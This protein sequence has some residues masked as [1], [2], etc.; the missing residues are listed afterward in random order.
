MARVK[1]TLDKL[2]QIENGWVEENEEIVDHLDGLNRWLRSKNVELEII[3]NHVFLIS[4][5]PKD[6]SNILLRY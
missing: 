2:E 4:N 1:I 6:I 5:D 3:Q